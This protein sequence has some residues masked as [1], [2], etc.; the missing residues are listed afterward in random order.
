MSSGALIQLKTVG[1]QSE[2]LTQNSTTSVFNTV[3]QKKIN[4]TSETICLQHK[5]TGDFGGKIV[6][7]LPRIGDMISKCGVRVT[8]PPV[9]YTSGFA[10]VEEIGNIMIKEASIEIGGKCIDKHFGVWMTIWNSLTMTQEETISNH[11]LTGNTSDLVGTK[12]SLITS[13]N[14]VPR[15]EIYI[16]LSFWF[17][18]NISLALPIVSIQSEQT[19]RIHIEFERVGSLIRGD[20]INPSSLHLES[21]EFL[22]DY[23]YLSE[24]DRKWFVKESFEMVIDQLHFVEKTSSHSVDNISL[25]SFNHPLLEII[26][27]TRD[28]TRIAATDI[29]KSHIGFTDSVDKNPTEQASLKLNNVDRFTQQT[30]RYFQNIQTSRHHASSSPYSGIN[31]YSFSDQPESL[32]EYTGALYSSELDNIVLSIQYSGASRQTQT[33][34]TVYS[35]GYNVL[36]FQR[37][38]ARLR[39]VV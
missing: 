27:V 22:A 13:P 17:T 2:N 9:G 10:W 12:L 29:T 1:S 16:P 30:G 18:R 5:G 32:F 36:S 28:V 4:F 6:V 24:K 15:K 25:S 11:N 7:E 34:T 20:P 14:P 23:M 37:G 39:Y 31:V 21:V 35:R 26:W 38:Y 19:P 3:F 8:L 33:Q